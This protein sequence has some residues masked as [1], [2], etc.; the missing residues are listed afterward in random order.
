MADFLMQFFVEY[1]PKDAYDKGTS[2]RSVELTA[3][4]YIKNEMMF[5]MVPLFPFTLIFKHKY[6]RLYFLIQCIRIKKCYQLL[7]TKKFN[8]L[9]K[10]WLNAKLKKTCEDP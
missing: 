4:R 5:D 1:Y 9:V 7:D 10:K 3:Q 2:I 6:S 8:A